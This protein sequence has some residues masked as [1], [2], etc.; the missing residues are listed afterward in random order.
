M[1][2]CEDCA[3]HLHKPNKYDP[4][5]PSSFEFLLFRDAGLGKSGC[6]DPGSHNVSIR[7]GLYAVSSSL[8]LGSGPD[9]FVC[10]AQQP[11]KHC[12]PDGH[13]FLEIFPAPFVV[14]PLSD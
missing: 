8:S 11:H 4:R 13:L 7:A 1:D 12:T 10:Y 14:L 3:Q 9:K 6:C 2:K 5:P